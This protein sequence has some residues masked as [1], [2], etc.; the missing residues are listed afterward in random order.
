LQ[1]QVCR[2]VLH[3]KYSG[4]VLIHSSSGGSLGPGK[5]P[6]SIEIQASKQQNNDSNARCQAYASK[7]CK[8]SLR[9]SVL[10][11]RVPVFC[12]PPVRAAFARSQPML[13]A[14]CAPWM[15]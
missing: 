11:Y 9:S 8:V 1:Q 12:L 4:E 3:L 13:S 2:Q 15:A 10:M 5:T 6:V 7:K 14:L